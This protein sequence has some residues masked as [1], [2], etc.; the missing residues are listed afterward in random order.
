M[1]HAGSIRI[2]LV[3]YFWHELTFYFYVAP[4]LTPILVERILKKKL[5]VDIR[6]KVKKLDKLENYMTTKT[7]YNF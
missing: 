6:K 1:C 4:G 2:E 5:K 3:C 7:Q